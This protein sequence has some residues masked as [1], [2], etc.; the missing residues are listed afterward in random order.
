MSGPDLK[1]ALALEAEVEQSLPMPL[2]G[3]LRCAAGELL[4]LVGP[5][6]AG[7]TSLLRML[8]GLMRPQQGRVAVGGELWCDTAQGLL[9][10]PQ[11]RHVGMVFQ[12]YALMPHLD[13]LGNVALSLLHLPHGERLQQAR[14]WL[15]HVGLSAGSRHAGRRRC[16]AANNSAWRWRG[17]WRAGPGCCCSTSRSRRWTR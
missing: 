8:A 17:R 6:G 5:S 3:R 15:D 4:A 7:K 16:R 13:A 11:R 2:S 1:A 12:N 9:L 10:P 14:H